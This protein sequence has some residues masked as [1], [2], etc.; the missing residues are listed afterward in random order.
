MKYSV[1]TFVLNPY[2]EAAGDVLAASLA[3]IGFDTFVPTQEGV[4]AY[5]QTSLLDEDAIAVLVNDFPLPDLAITYS[6]ADAPDENWNATWEQEHTF[7]PVELP[8]G[9][10]VVVVPRQ[11]FGSGEHATTRMMIQ[12]LSSLDLQGATIIDA[13]CGTGILGFAAMLLGAKELVAYDIDEWSVSNARDNL[14]LN[15][16]N[17]DNVDLRLGDVN[18]LT[19]ADKADVLLA[20]INRNILLADL[21]SF[22]AHTR[23]GGRILLSG[24]Y[25]ADVP[26]LIEK[27]SEHGLA[28]AAQLS[29][30]EWR[31]LSLILNN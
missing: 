18:V 10:Q 15:E 27:A 22:V 1:A 25:D 12:L 24:F 4:V 20:N 13:G 3:N 16:I 28:L 11:A 5:V 29:D 23:P 21:P 26:L 31:A 7:V 19:E 9:K 14:C 30:G 2:S 17:P 8:G 6:L